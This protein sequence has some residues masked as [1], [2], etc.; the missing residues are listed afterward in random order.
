MFGDPATVRVYM[1]TVDAVSPF[2][3]TETLRYAI[4]LTPWANTLAVPPGT[5]HQIR[6]AIDGLTQAL[7]QRQ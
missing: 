2:G 4:D 6:R 1:V 7:A 5:L 3:P